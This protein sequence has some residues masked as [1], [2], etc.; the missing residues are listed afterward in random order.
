MGTQALQMQHFCLS[1]VAFL[2]KLP[3][4][5][6][7][8]VSLVFWPTLVTG[9]TGKCYL[10]I[11]LILLKQILI[12]LFI[13]DFWHFCLTQNT[14]DRRYSQIHMKP[15]WKSAG[16]F[17]LLWNPVP[18]QSKC[19]CPLGPVR[20]DTSIT[21]KQTIFYLGGCIDNG[22]IISILKGPSNSHSANSQK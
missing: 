18:P 2:S 15:F 7:L 11:L 22:N 9:V 6:L 14:S 16:S 10:F 20:Q 3:C 19:I 17:I 5:G 12:E 13:W 21:A 8:K 4:D 1:K